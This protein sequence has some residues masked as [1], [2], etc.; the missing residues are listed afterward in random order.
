[1]GFTLTYPTLI[2][3][4]LFTIFSNEISAQEIRVVGKIIDK[5]TK[6]PIES[7]TISVYNKKDIVFNA[8]SDTAG[9]FRIPLSLFKKASSITIR[10]LSYSDL[11]MDD[12]SKIDAGGKSDYSLGIYQIDPKGKQLQEVIVRKRRR[13]SDTTRIDLSKEKF[14]HSVMIEDIFSSSFGFSKDANGQLFYKGKPVSIVS[15]NGGD[16]FGKNNM[17]VYHLL[18][19]LILNNIQVV[20]T[21]IDSVTNTTLLRPIVKINLSFKDKYEK[22]KFGNLNAGAGT[23]QRYLANTNLFSF[24]KTEQI[25]LSLNSNNVNAGNNTIQPPKVGFSPTGNNETANSAK[26]TYR[27]LYAGTLEVNFSVGG[28]RDSKNFFTE[29][30]LRQETINLTSHT[31]NSSNI[32]SF[33]FSDSKFDVKYKIDSF[34]SINLTQTFD[35]SKTR[36]SDSLSYNIQLDSQ[37]TISQLDKLRNATTDLLSTKMEYQKK[38]SSKKGRTLDIDIEV[39]NN[40]YNIDE[41]DNASNLSDQGIYKYF[42]NGNRF[43]KE[44]K[45]AISSGFTEPIN[46]NSYIDFFIAH[47]RETLN[48]SPQINSDTAIIS[49]DKPALLTNNYFQSGIKFHETLTNLSINATISGLLDM[50]NIEQIH[51]NNKVSFLN[52]DFELMVDYRINKNKNLI[53]G[54]SDKENYPKLQQLVALNSTFDLISQTSGNIYLRPEERKNIKVDYTTKLSNSEYISLSGEF[55]HY[56]NKFGF[57]IDNSGNSVSEKMFIGN[58]GNSNGGKISFS[59]LKNIRGDQYLNY[60]N[61]V[62]YQENPTLF[63][64]KLSLDNSITFNQSLSASLMLIK[65][66]L[67]VKPLFAFS[68]GRYFYE[69][70]SIDMTTITNSDQVSL[71]FKTLELNLYPLF[72]Y[73]HSMNDNSSFSMN[74]EL[75]RSILKNY[76]AIWIQVYDIFNSYKFYNNYVG[77]SGYQSVR[78]SN[79]QRY[80]MLGV[81]LQ[82]NNLK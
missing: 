60:S 40:H 41:F 19:A 81:S 59:W 6:K 63:N 33:G 56:S 78:Y 28:K 37:S 75:K 47:K 72:S 1:M 20:E 30:D 17:D 4:F 21:N 65:P 45:Y 70:N 7:A 53:F 9:Q 3:L 24:K 13:Y 27:N 5:K 73:N 39:D 80:L 74:G 77:A 23:V 58:I 49:L 44:N 71:R 26:F 51:D 50:R 62:T 25:S 12:I 8:V 82:F 52:P 64:N 48:Y 68:W 54:Y 42:I 10:A 22:G 11:E 66:L 34:S 55:E 31:F 18:P 36:E 2:L 32:R 67:S 61:G 16:F 35:H 15:V 57:E 79:L 14:E 29:T 43:V 69:T 76:G 46:N 38:F